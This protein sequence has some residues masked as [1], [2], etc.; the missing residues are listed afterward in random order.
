[1][2]RLLASS[3]LLLYYYALVP[4]GSCA[5]G[6]RPPLVVN[7]DCLVNA[8]ELSLS[9]KTGT[10]VKG[11]AEAE[12]NTDYYFLG[13]GQ[14]GG[15]VHRAI[16]RNPASRSYI[17]K[18]YFELE[19]AEKDE[20]RLSILPSLLNGVED[21]QV[22]QMI[23]PR[24]GNR[25]YLSDVQ[26]Q[27]ILAIRNHPSL[28]P[29]AQRDQVL[30]RYDRLLER[31]KDHIRRDPHVK[32]ITLKPYIEHDGTVTGNAL[33]YKY[34]ADDGES[35]FF[36]IHSDQVIVSPNGRMTIIDPN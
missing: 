7:P 32:S 36:L 15:R 16:P 18:D 29:R 1:M 8:M 6:D 35:L 9:P 19:D 4:A 20:R 2:M 23:R 17:R 28:L 14:L 22:T 5:A 26:G 31:I 33:M 10:P 30:A 12:P 11:L 3:C 13:Q 24:E 21:I 34:R 27:S 25:L